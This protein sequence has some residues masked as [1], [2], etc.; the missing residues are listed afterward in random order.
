M[1]ISVGPVGSKLWQ[2]VAAD[3]KP[4]ASDLRLA[5]NDVF[6]ETDTFKWFIWNG[7]T[8]NA[9]AAAAP[10]VVPPMH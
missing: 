1:S 7:A 2:G 6:F 5:V 4:T 3:T 10:Y 8:W 9:T